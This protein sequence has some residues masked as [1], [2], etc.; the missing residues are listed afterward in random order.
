MLAKR[1]AAVKAKAKESRQQKGARRKSPKALTRMPEAHPGRRCPTGEG[2]SRNTLE[3]PCPRK[4]QVL[5]AALCAPS[6]PCRLQGRH[7]ALPQ[8]A[9][10]A[11]AFA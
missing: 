10:V 1:P 11:E 9:G 8:A 7:A 3:L 2:R 4:A 5:V 6:V